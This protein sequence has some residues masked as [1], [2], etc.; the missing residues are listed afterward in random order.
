MVR[1]GSTRANSEPER[2][3]R[4]PIGVVADRT[5]VSE[6]VLRAWER[7]YGA[8]RPARTEGGQRLYSDADV[9]RLRLLRQLTRDGRT[10]GQIA[11]L[12]TSALLTLT[13]DDAQQRIGPAGAAAEARPSGIR[14]VP[15]AESAGGATRFQEA[16]LAAAR[17]MDSQR[18]TGI[19]TRAVVSLRA[20]EFVMDLA[21][22]LL[23]RIGEE[24]ESGGVHPRHEHLLSVGLRQVML[25][26]LQGFTPAEEA[27]VA[28]G[29]TLA[30]ERHEFGALMACV[31]AAEE[32]WRVVYLGSDLPGADVARGAA[33]VGA[34]LV[35]GSVVDEPGT[36][37]FAEELAALS[38]ELR[39]GV[40]VIIGGRLSGGVLPTLAQHGAVHLTDLEALRE[41]LRLHDKPGAEE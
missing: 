20:G 13:E 28:V 25:W 18:L 7:R 27:P 5:G 26:L 32:G 33:Q 9:L 41:R 14:R 1:N 39:P 6:H 10:I 40:E 19:L 24:W 37:V 38:A 3:P 35:L 36:A 21:A 31:V 23:E 8:V 15:G 2:V 30:G 17:A 16:A 29:A 12:T 22:P 34:R 4:H 11:S